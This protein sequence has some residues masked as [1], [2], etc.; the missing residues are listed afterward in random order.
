MQVQ[1]SS[2]GI[3][4]FYITNLILQCLDLIY[5]CIRSLIDN[6]GFHEVIQ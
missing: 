1:K 3:Y 4:L 6:G 5:L 2:Q